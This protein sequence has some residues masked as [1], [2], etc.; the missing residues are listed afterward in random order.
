MNTLSVKSDVLGA[1]TSFLCLLHCIATPLFFLV[2]S[3][4]T[5]G[6]CEASPV[7]WKQ[8]DILFVLISFVAVY[9]SIK[10]SR[11][12]IIQILFSISWIVLLGI[13]MNEQFHWMSIHE[14]FIF[15]PTLSL[16]AL[17]LYNRKDCK[18]AGDT[19]CS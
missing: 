8:F 4:A 10:I 14:N 17:H 18:C 6:C 15:V 16:I 2:D 13:V 11:R 5:N 19:C 12:R 9:R 7:W 1:A 3:C